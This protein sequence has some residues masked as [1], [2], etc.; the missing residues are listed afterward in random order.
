MPAKHTRDKTISSSN[1]KTMTQQDVN[2]WLSHDHFASRL[3]LRYFFSRMNKCPCTGFTHCVIVLRSSGFTHITGLVSCN[4]S[5]SDGHLL[6]EKS[7]AMAREHHNERR[8]CWRCSRSRRETPCRRKIWVK[9]THTTI[10]FY[11]SLILKL[12]SFMQPIDTS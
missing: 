12:N 11:S 8:D 2:K 3:K 4:V 6:S 10:Q 9:V 1:R 5:R 7:Y